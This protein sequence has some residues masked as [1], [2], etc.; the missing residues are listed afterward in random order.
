MRPLQGSV[1]AGRERRPPRLGQ[2]VREGAVGQ[3]TLTL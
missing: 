3:P 1:E 2:A